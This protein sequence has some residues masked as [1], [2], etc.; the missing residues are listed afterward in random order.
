MVRQRASALAAV[1]VLCLPLS[2]AAQAFRASESIN[3]GGNNVPVANPDIAYDSRD[4]QYL[5]VTGKGFIEARRLSAGGG[6]L[7]T[8]TVTDNANYS[9]QPRVAYSPD[10]ASGAGGYLV[11]WHETIGNLAVVR[12]RI[13]KATDP[14]VATGSFNI[15]VSASSGGSNWTM[16][17]AVAYATGS[18]EFLVAWQGQYPGA[19][20]VYFARVNNVG[21]V[22]SSGGVANVLLTAGTTDWERDPSVAYNPD[23]DEFYV[24]YAGFLN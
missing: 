18:N 10:V 1:L 17:A 2:A 9:Q 21:T 22:L 19:A 7:Q 8:F 6:L 24:S 12:G 15:G 20:D 23:D 4:N 16:G 13:F 14:S 3:T 11:T 5:Q